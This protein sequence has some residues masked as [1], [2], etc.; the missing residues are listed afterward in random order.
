MN[1]SQSSNDTFPTAM[2]IAAAVEIHEGLL[3]ALKSLKSALEMKEKAIRRDRQDRKDASARRDPFDAEPG[4]FRLCLSFGA[5]HA[6][7]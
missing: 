6:G 1:M 7:H 3:P 4:I 2:H 5:V